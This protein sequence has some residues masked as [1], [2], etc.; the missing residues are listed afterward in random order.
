M[1]CE[2]RTEEVQ[3]LVLK[4][5]LSFENIF[6]VCSR[7]K[8]TNTALFSGWRKRKR[9]VT[10]PSIVNVPD[11]AWLCS[12]HIV[13]TLHFF[14]ALASRFGGQNSEQAS[15][16]WTTHLVV[17]FVVMKRVVAWY[18][19]AVRTIKTLLSCAKKIVSNT[20]APQATA[21]FQTSR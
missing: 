3:W 17:E 11:Q 16:S 20:V 10:Q 2:T 14:E 13:L 9:C 5:R 15:Q 12:Y 4:V 18:P 21:V 19:F 8:T 6:P 1:V 7:R